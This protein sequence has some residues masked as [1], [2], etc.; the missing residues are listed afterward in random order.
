[1]AAGDVRWRVV[2]HQI[3]GLGPDHPPHIHVV[4]HVDGTAD[5]TAGGPHQLSTKDKNRHMDSP[6]QHLDIRFW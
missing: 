4:A 5:T 6:D 3:D 1:M 2:A